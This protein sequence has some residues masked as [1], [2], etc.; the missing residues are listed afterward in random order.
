MKISRGMFESST[1]AEYL[2]QNPKEVEDYLEFRHILDWR[3]Y[4]W[5]LESAR[6]MA[7]AVPPEKVKDLEEQYGRAEPR[8]RD[9]RGRIRNQW[10][11]KPLAQ[12]A[13]E[14]GR[15]AQYKLSYGYG[16]SIH[17]VNPEGMLA[18]VDLE[19]GKLVLE[20]VGASS[21]AK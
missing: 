14:V 4:Q 12:M 21:T 3:R 16:A 10:H 6:D 17:H 11:Q 9:G 18:Y 2:R 7:K 1:F 8:F 19:D 20:L 13:R 5:L 15:G